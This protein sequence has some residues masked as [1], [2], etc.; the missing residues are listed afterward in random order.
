MDTLIRMKVDDLNETL[1]DFLRH[2]FKGKS[3][4]VHILEAEPEMDE[5]EFVLRD[6]TARKEIMESI[7]E[8][9]KGVG[10]KKYN[11]V[12]ELKQEFLNEPKP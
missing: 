1:I 5:T 4:E 11:T 2:S 6:P 7:E 12:E 3:M 9:N 8:V 10:L